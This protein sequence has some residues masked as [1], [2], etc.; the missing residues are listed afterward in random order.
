MPTVAAESPGSADA[1]ALMEA[2]SSRL[3]DIPGDSGKAS[4][5]VADVTAPRALFAVALAFLGKELMP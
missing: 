5:D 2:L 3:A 1:Q 4:F